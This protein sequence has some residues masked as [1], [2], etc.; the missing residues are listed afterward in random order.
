MKTGPYQERDN[1]DTAEK[2]GNAPGSSLANILMNKIG[3]LFDLVA[4]TPRAERVTREVFAHLDVAGYN[5]A[6][7]RYR[8]D[9]RKYPDRVILGTETL[10]GEVAR[11]W[12]LVRTVPSVIGDFVWTGW[13]YLG[14]SG[15]G[16]WVPGKRFA[17]L[18][19]PYPYLTAGPGMFD[20]TGLPDASVRL[21]QAAWG[22]LSAPAVAV[23]P[24]DRAGRS[25]ARV[26]WRSTDAVESWSWRGCVGRTA[27]IE[28]YSADEEV[29]LILNGRPLGRRKPKGFI[30]RYRTAYEAGILVAVGYREGEQCGRTEL[31]TAGSNVALQVVP[32][33]PRLAADGASLAFLVV[34]IA[35]VDGVVEMLADTEV[36]LAVDG[37][38]ILEAV[39]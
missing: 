8:R 39:R 24:L 13:D 10:P 1:R 20:I 30:A 37:P 28:V 33:S 21:A 32:E 17:P 16:V 25:V 23:R 7:G 2:A 27:E 12:H 9:A 15:I 19:K 3:V 18:L 34:Q 14:E 5:Y 38:A 35:D 29:E 6:L 31:R 11:A 26:S 22:E 4:R 36:T